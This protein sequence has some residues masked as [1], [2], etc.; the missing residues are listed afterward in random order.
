MDDSE[1]PAQCNA[2]F[3]DRIRTD[4]GSAERANGE[5]PLV[6][7]AREAYRF[8]EEFETDVGLVPDFVKMDD[9]EVVHR[10]DGT[11]PSNIAMSML[12]TVA[13]DE[14]GFVETEA[15]R[16][17]LGN[18]LDTLERLEKWNGLFYRWYDAEDGSLTAD[19]EDRHI[20]TVDNGHLT[21]V[22][23]IVSQAYPEL[24]DRA[25]DLVEEED[26]SPFHSDDD[27]RLVGAYYFGKD[28]GEEGFGDWTYGYLNS[29]HRIA[30]YCAIGKGDFPKRHWW[31]PLR[32]APPGEREEDTTQNADGKWVTYDGVEV[33]EGH[34]K[35]DEVQ[36]VPSWGGAMFE[37]LMP[38]LYIDEDRSEDAWAPN[39]RNHVRLQIEY[40]EERGWPVWGLSSSGKAGGYDTFGVPYAG[41]WADGYRSGP[42]VTPH[43]TG[44]AAMVD[45]ATARENVRALRELGVDGPYG[46]YD[47]VNAETGEVAERYYSLDQGM[48][49]CGIANAVTDG[50]LREYFHADPIGSTPEDLL[51]RETFTV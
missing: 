12:S 19:Y 22:L 18:A 28:D 17:R 5:G 45:E 21:A 25:H 26:Y 20:S 46:L 14:L 36:Y 16:E 24:Y 27:G 3:T 31:Q 11:S 13:A 48:L 38:S 2:E 37:T 32:T 9:G 42:W 39:N 49:L 29:E 43:A 51:E 23:V 35:H 7:T 10:K 1:Q 34:Y 30:S 8:F 4:G 33:Y 44:L 41:A 50:A 40:A 15:A 47:A 6:D